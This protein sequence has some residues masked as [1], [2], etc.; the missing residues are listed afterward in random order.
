MIRAYIESVF[1]SDVVSGQGKG[2]QAGISQD[3]CD[4]YTLSYDDYDDCIAMQSQC[5]TVDGSACVFPF[6]L[7]GKE[8]TTCV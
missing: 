5:K 7:R 6:M 8:K 3:D 1:L 4:Y 2:N